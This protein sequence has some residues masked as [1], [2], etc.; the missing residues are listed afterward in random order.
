MAFTD[1]RCNRAVAISTAPRRISHAKLQFAFRAE[2]R[3]LEAIVRMRLFLSTHTTNL[4]LYR[5]RWRVTEISQIILVLL[6]SRCPVLHLPPSLAAYLADRKTILVLTKVDISGHVRAQAWI[7]YFQEHHP[8]SRIVQV[9][10]YIEKDVIGDQGPKLYEPHLPA[11]FRETLVNAIKEVHAELLE[12]PEEIKQ[13]P[14]RLKNWL[15]SVKREID[16]E[17]VLSPKDEKVGLSVGG[18]AVPRPK[19]PG[20]AQGE[21]DEQH[22]EPTHLTIGLIG[23]PNVGKSSLLNALFGAHRVRASKTPGKV[24][25]NLNSLKKES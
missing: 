18:A 21:N 22:Q 7:N 10:S 19:S 5:S 14:E 4:S 8:N 20:D 3:S 12:P 15:P 2:S 1:R 6:D 25:L 13:H 9:E 24:C 17:S 23:Q 11:S 16:W